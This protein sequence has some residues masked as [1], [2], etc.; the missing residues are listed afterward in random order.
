M[1]RNLVSYQLFKIVQPLAYFVLVVTQQNLRFNGSSINIRAS[2]A[3]G[4]F[5]QHL[6]FIHIDSLK[7]SMDFGLQIKGL[8]HLNFSAGCFTLEH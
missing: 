5:A 7:P 6:P 8:H 2:T 3:F 4:C 1:L